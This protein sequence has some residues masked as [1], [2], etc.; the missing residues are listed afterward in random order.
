MS[1]IH[2]LHPNLFHIDE[3]P[4]PTG[5]QMALE[6]IDLEIALRQRLADTIQSRLSWAFQLRESLESGGEGGEF[7]L[8]G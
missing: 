6:E 5:Q 8:S 1:R 2:R 3:Y 7:G 4:A